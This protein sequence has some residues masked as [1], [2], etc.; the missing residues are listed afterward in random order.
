MDTTE[1]RVKYIQNVIVKACLLVGLNITVYDGKI[2][3]VDQRQRK[4]VA[5]WEPQH[6]MDEIYGGGS[7]GLYS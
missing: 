7:N 2:G 3:F 1:E 5:L 6:T 4:I